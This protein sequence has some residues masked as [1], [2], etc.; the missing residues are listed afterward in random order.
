MKKAEMGC[1][2]YKPGSAGW[3]AQTK[4]QS[5]GGRLKLTKKVTS[6]CNSWGSAWI[7]TDFYNIYVKYIMDII[8]NIFHYSTRNGKAY[9]WG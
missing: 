2:E 8:N 7:G 9:R 1:L 3:E 4:P 5:Y 6:A